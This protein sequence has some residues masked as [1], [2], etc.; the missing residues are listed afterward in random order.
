MEAFVATATVGLIGWLVHQRLAG[1]R[2]A[3]VAMAVAAVYLP[4][5]VVG[6]SLMSEA[7]LVPLSLLAVN[8]AVR[9]RAAP[10]ATRWLVLAGF[11]P[12]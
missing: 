8:C 1:R 2:T 11:L 5:I 9:A 4:L 6:T 3:L 12:A 10:H 7:L